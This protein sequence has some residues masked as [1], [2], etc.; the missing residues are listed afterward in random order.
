MAAC[1]VSSPWRKQVLS[2]GGVYSEDTGDSAGCSSPNRCALHKKDLFL[3]GGS[4]S[5]WDCRLIRRPAKDARRRRE[6]CLGRVTR[7]SVWSQEKFLLSLRCHRITMVQPAE[8][9]KGLN[10]AFTLAN[11]CRPTCWRVLRESQM[12]PVLVIVE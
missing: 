11:F 7:K 12:S 6:P 1:K 2:N 3:F 9:R 5:V 8:S 10:L 4:S